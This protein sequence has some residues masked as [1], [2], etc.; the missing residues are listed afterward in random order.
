MSGS[1]PAVQ[2]VKPSRLRGSASLMAA[3]IALV[4]AWEGCKKFAYLDPVGIPTACFG[5]TKN[6]K[7][8][9]KFTQ[10]ECDNMLIAS[11]VSHEAGMMKCLTRTLPEST[12]TAALSFTYNAGVGNFCGSTFARKLNAGDIQGACDELPRWNKATVWKKGIP[13]RVTLPGLTNRRADEKAICLLGR[14]G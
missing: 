7:M 6:I 12:Y 8:G 14:N 3:G 11:L 4:G 9:M 1:I 13:I 10:S 2:M 5:E